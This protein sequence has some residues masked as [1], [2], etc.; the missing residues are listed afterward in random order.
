MR[1]ALDPEHLALRAELKEYFDQL[2]TPIAH[3][4][5]EDYQTALS[6]FT[7]VTAFNNAVFLRRADLHFAL[8]TAGAAAM[9]L[10]DRP[11]AGE[12][13]SRIPEGALTPRGRAAMS[14]VDRTSPG[15]HT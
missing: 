3:Y 7:A 2:V 13:F 9:A 1:L 8:E 15:R 14:A 11:R 6:I 12:F 5:T 10:G 4:L